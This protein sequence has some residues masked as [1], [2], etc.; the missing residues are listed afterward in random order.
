MAAP[1]LLDT[2]T[3]IVQKHCPRIFFHSQSHLMAQN[4]CYSTTHYVI[5]LYSAGREGRDVLPPYVSAL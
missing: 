2:Q 4:G 3:P 5:H 1:G